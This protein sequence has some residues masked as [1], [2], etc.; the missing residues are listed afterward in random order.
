MSTSPAQHF[1]RRIGQLE[2]ESQK[3]T[4][5][6][7]LFFALR[8]LFFLAFIAL[9]IFY[10]K[11]DY[12]SIYLWFS[13]LALATFLA[14]VK[15]D[16]LYHARERLVKTKILLNNNELKYLD[17]QFAGFEEGKNFESLNPALAGDLDL[18]GEGSLFQYLNRCVTRT[19]TAKFAE[20]ICTPLQQASSI[21]EKQ[22]AIEELSKK[23]DFVESFRARGLLTSENGNEVSRLQRWLNQSQENLLT[24]KLISYLYPL[25]MATCLALI[26]SGAL[27]PSW[28][29]A[30]LVAAYFILYGYHKKVSQAHENLSNSAGTFKKYAA[31][32]KLVEAESFHSSLLSDM[33]LT[34][35]HDDLTASESLKKLFRLLERFDY[36]NNMLISLLLNSLVLFD[37]HTYIHLQ[38][39]KGRHKMVVPGWFEALTSIDALF[40]FAV[41]RFNNPHTTFPGPV[42]GTFTLEAHGLGHP[43]IPSKARVNN[44]I[45]LHKSPR[46][47][48]ITGANMAGKSTFL[49]AMGVNLVLAM[50][51]APVC[52]THFRFTPCLLV[53]S[54]NIRDSL[55]QNQ[56]YFYAELVRLKS[57]IKQ[58]EE[59]PKTMVFLDEILRGTNS[60]DKHTGTVGLLEKLIALGAIVV[61]ATH[62]LGVGLLADKHPAIATN[63]CFEVELENDQL[64]FDYKLKPGI[65]QKLNASFLM[66]KMGLIEKTYKG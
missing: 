63:H 19:G 33:K 17:Y 4:K 45:S 59:Q 12:R 39:W 21:R 60:Q 49:R 1:K 57:I 23:A 24:L 61:I 37:L 53:S 26:I 36:R 2:A 65:S 20:G 13:A 62:D 11:S 54:I 38:Q 14:V 30:P 42:E 58:V 47:M 31:L 16:L 27:A 40:G 41:F 9:L 51:G 8:S 64:V 25:I 32:I 6:F 29:I 35:S 34:F 44:D 28:V 43:L 5:Y 52:A 15:W 48:V 22:E 55:A 10:I 66:H 3:L 50:N 56:S 7:R 46:V 18:F